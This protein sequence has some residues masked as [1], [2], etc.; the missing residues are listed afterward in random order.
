MLPEGEPRVVTD[1][2]D[3]LVIRE[4]ELFLLTDPEGHIPAGNGEGLGL[5]H[6]DT[7]YLSTWDMGLIGVQPIVLLSTAEEA[8]WMEQVMTNPELQSSNGERLPSGSLE[9]RR[10]RV[11]DQS[12]LETTRFTNFGATELHFALQFFF[13]ADFADMFEVRGLHRS[14]HGTSLDVHMRASGVTYRYRGLD[15]VARQT[16]V[17]FRPRPDELNEREAIF[18]LRIPARSSREISA[19]VVLDS[20]AGSGAVRRSIE[21]VGAQHTEWRAT[22]TQVVTSNHLLNRAIN[23][24]IS[25]LRVL[26]VDR[27]KDRY[28]VAGVPW[29]DTLFGRD[30]LL[31]GYM[32]LAYQPGIA[33]SVLLTLARYQGESVDPSREEEPGKI[34]HE[35]RVC[36]SANL[37]EVPF[38]RYYGS[39][40]AT[41]LFLILAGEYYRWTADLDLMRELEPHIRRSLQWMH[42]YGDLDGDGLV[43]YMRKG[44]HGLDNQGWKDSWD[45]IVDEHGNVLK[46]P[47][48]LVEVQGYAYAAKLVMADVY[49]GLGDSKTAARLRK[50]AKALRRRVERAFW[51]DRGFYAMALGEDK[52]AAR[53]MSSNAGQLL[54]SGLPSVARARRQIKRLVRSD[55]FSGWGIRTISSYS[56]RYNPI[57]Y[58]LGT[59][60]PHDNAVILAGFKRY[61]AEHELNE[62]AG[63]LFHASTSFAYSRLPELFGGAPRQAHQAPVPYPVACR[64]QAFAAAALPSI[65]TSMLGI[66]PRAQEN[67]LYIV[68]PQLPPWL[69]VV[70]LLGLRVGEARLNLSFR[71]TGP[72]TSFEVSSEEGS[73]EVVRTDHWPD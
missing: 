53:V 28:P 12:M 61:G 57:G 47:I 36:E 44:P 52:A 71:G 50:E 48:A 72:L 26:W 70:E 9:I 13:D 27:G 62:V 22:G 65:L 64:P 23:R 21:S 66:A 1:I 20:A 63:A 42:E 45:A 29:F 51:L 54:W 59:I 39:I 10:H 68:R 18:R 11:L 43:E 56:K 4:Q 60:W 7:R 69:E 46:P 33:R 2:R 37:G 40:D 55:M 41:A 49:D 73:L 8:F 31:A 17:G 38:G 67:R 34:I 25:D 30:S 16:R 24:S 35:R 5:Y 15:H 19:S 14:R 58:H 3:A 6:D 32:S